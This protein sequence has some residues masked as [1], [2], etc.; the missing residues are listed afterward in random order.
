MPT[1]T[2]IR[3]AGP[4]GLACALGTRGERERWA[5]RV[6]LSLPRGSRMRPKRWTEPAI[7]AAMWRLLRGRRVYP[8][9][10]EFKEA[11]LGGLYQAIGR[12]RGGHEACAERYGV[13]RVT[14]RKSPVAESE[15]RAH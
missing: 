3:A 15:P 11:G 9:E 6:G 5:A 2:R 13:T 14:K 1:L 10:R 4:R 7:D 8:S 12:T